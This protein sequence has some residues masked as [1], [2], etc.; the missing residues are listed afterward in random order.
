MHWIWPTPESFRTRGDFFHHHAKVQSFGLWGGI[1]RIIASGRVGER[2]IHQGLPALNKTIAVGMARIQ[3]GGKQARVPLWVP[4]ETPSILKSGFVLIQKAV[5]GWEG[6][7]SG[8]RSIRVGVPRQH[9]CRSRRL[10]RR[11]F[12]WRG[13]PLDEGP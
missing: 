11:G 12:G 9:A 7:L 13:D 1:Q 6:V 10:S 2:P 3:P 8:A 4:P 5:H